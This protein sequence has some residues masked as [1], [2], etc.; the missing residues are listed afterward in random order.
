MKINEK[1]P[2]E[3]L[4]KFQLI[5]TKTKWARS[6][7]I[8]YPPYRKCEKADIFEN[9][10]PSLN[11]LSSFSIC[12]NELKLCEHFNWIFFI[13]FLRSQFICIKTEWA[14]S[15]TIGYLTYRKCEKANI[16]EIGTPS[17]NKSSTFSFGYT[18]LK[19]NESF[20]WT[21]SSSYSK[22][23]LICMKTVWARS[24]TVGHFWEWNTIF[25]RP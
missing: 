22:S 25:Q 14:R 16:F 15:D 20:N 1:G 4:A 11:G 3:T 18:K 21:F 10:T 19:F 8:G 2:I 6:D 9:G 17:L 5:S 12:S 23:Q 7:S 13:S 24:F